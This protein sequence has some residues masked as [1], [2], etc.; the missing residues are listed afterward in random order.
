[1]GTVRSDSRRLWERVSAISQAARAE[2]LHAL[3]PP[4]S[5]GAARIGDGS[6]A[7]TARLA[8]LFE[9]AQRDPELRAVLVGMLRGP[10]TG[11]GFKG[12]RIPPGA[13]HFLDRLRVHI[14][15]RRIG[16]WDQCGNSPHERPQAFPD[17]RR[18]LHQDRGPVDDVVVEL[19]HD[20]RTLS[21]S[22]LAWSPFALNSGG[23]DA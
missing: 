11:S 3:M 13:N 22:R 15:Q 21:S 18:T 5:E 16:G 6:A 12:L 8:E 20:F 9:D 14:A 1:M 19:I 10:T 7:S 2:L 17:R 4:D 23:V